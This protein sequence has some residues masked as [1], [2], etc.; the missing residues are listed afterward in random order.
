MMKHNVQ[1]A[2]DEESCTHH[3]VK[4]MGGSYVLVVKN[5]V[6]KLDDQVKAEQFAGK[7]VKINGNLE[8]GTHTFMSSTWKKII[9]FDSSP[10]WKTYGCRSSQPFCFYKGDR[11]VQAVFSMV[12]G[13]NM[14][15]A[16]H[17]GDHDGCLLNRSQ[18]L[19]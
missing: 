1:G 10:D 12:K 9:V 19:L 8:A 13:W 11:P 14:A 15:A 5:D 6:Y 16:S 18:R 2:N 7:K 4:D 3:C 17:C